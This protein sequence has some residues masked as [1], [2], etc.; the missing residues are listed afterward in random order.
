MGE[1]RG[2]SGVG[3]KLF[4]VRATG[5]DYDYIPLSLEGPP[6]AKAPNQN[7]SDSEGRKLGERTGLDTPVVP[8]VNDA[9]CGVARK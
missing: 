9:D 5:S 7:M 6:V 8:A 1:V 2:T 3:V 4:S